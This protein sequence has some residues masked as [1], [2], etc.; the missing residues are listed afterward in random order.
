M[1][2]DQQVKLGESLFFLCN[3]ICNVKF[4]FHLSGF[5]FF[6]SGLYSVES[7]SDH[8]RLVWL[9]FRNVAWCRESLCFMIVSLLK[10]QFPVTN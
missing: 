3:E 10:L 9:A 1:K 2:D 5:F 4:N 7:S 8:S 6:A